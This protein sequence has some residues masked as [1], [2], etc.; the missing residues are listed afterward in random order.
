M[1][2]CGFLVNLPTRYFA[3]SKLLRGVTCITYESDEQH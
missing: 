3:P 2:F 1:N